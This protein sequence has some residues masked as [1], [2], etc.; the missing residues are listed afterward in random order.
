[1]LLLHQ[2]L[3]VR[4]LIKST[5][6]CLVDCANWWPMVGRRLFSALSCTCSQ[7]AW[8]ESNTLMQLLPF[9]A[10]CSCWCCLKKGRDKEWRDHNKHFVCLANTHWT[11][12]KVMPTVESGWQKGPGTQA[13]SSLSIWL[14]IFC[15]FIYSSLPASVCILISAYQISWQSF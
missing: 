6:I 1:M 11:D 15:K 2:S 8:P 9:L 10:H 4:S 7:A 3:G 14:A 13:L 12:W 5:L